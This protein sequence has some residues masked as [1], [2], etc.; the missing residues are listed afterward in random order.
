MALATGCGSDGADG[1]PVPVERLGTEMGEAQCSYMF[2][3]CNAQELME[4]LGAF[5]IETEGEC[6]QF[7]SGFVGG[8]LRPQIEAAVS[9][10]RMVYHADRMGECLALISSMSCEQM[11]EA[12]ASS[13][14]FAVP[15]CQNPF[16]GLVA[17]NGACAADMEC[18]SGTCVG[19]SMDFEGNITEGTCGDAADVG[20]ECDFGECGPGAYCEFGQGGQMCV[21]AK[22]AGASCDSDDEC[23]TDNCEGADP[24][25][26]TPGTCS[27]NYT[28]DGQ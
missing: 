20:S 6:V 12:M 11:A 18:A 24:M 8:L 2:E 13:E 9:S 1:G 17:A 15:G 3:C 22:A 10:G 16:E 14:N 19:E 25:N 27:A 28:C 5:M 7:F 26:Q 23:L 21:A 4:E